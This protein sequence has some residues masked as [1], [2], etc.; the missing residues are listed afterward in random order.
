MRTVRVIV[1]SVLALVLINAAFI[2]FPGKNELSSGD[3]TALAEDQIKT[4]PPDSI[5]LLF[6]GD[7]MAHTVNFRMTDYADIYR[8]MEPLIQA[9]DFSFINLETPVVNNIP[10]ASYPLFNVQQAYV[11]AAIDAGFNVFSLANNHTTDQG[12]GGV[13]STM[14]SMDELRSRRRIAFS[15]VRGHYRS[16]LTPAL[17]EAGNWKIGFISI[18]SFINV[19]SGN[20]LVYMV[21]YHQSEDLRQEFLNYIRA[22]QPL[23]DLLVIAVHD[24]QE[25]E[26]EPLERKKVFFRELADAGADIVWGHHSHVLQPWETRERNDGS[27]AVIMFSMGNFISGQIWNIDPEDQDNPRNATG[28]SCLLLVSFLKESGTA[29]VIL[30]DVHP[31]GAFNYRD[32]VKGMVVRPYE[33]LIGDEVLPEEW[34]TYYRDRKERLAWFFSGEKAPKTITP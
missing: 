33:S 16:P 3:P 2:F 19:W 10:Y 25:Y 18:T 9:A 1:A 13:L 7:L 28:D 11:E 14:Q 17:L 8:E 6:A 21:D 22:V 29:S 12:A 15:G 26:H 4:A 5:T 34:D 24:G 20:E 23:Y 27:K 30:D 31:Y 32:P